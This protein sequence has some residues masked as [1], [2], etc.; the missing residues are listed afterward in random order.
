MPDKS[1]LVLLV[2]HGLTPTTG[3]KLPGRARGLH[4][5]DDGRRQ[6]EAAA[7]RIAKI[8]KVVAI[9]SSPLERAR[10]TAAPHRAGPRHGR[11]H[12]A[13]ACSSWTSASGRAW[14]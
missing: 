11:A 4:L 12:R 9:Y 1:T 14:R 13:A 8:P 2:R 10:E 7:A 5:S 6:A 3:V